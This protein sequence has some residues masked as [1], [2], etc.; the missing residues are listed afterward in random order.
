MLFRNRELDRAF[1]FIQEADFDLFCLQEVPEGFLKRL[2][3]L[4]YHMAS[5]VDAERSIHGETVRMFVVTLSKFPITAQR[6][7]IYPDNRTRL[8]LRTRLFI[9]LMPSR[10]FSSIR[11][12]GGICVDIAVD[13]HIVRVFNLHLMLAYPRVREEEIELA[14][15]EHHK[16]HTTIVCGDFNILGKPHITILNWL[17][18]GTISDVVRYRRER[19]DMEKRFATHGL[20]NVLRGAMTHPLSYSQLDH[21][22]V[23]QWLVVKNQTVLRDRIGSD[24]HPIRVEL[25]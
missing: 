7:I 18:G 14:L 15:V 16:D 25:A 3:T 23:S 19:I 21:I 12:R 9:R 13:G 2:E 24:H 22:L 20:R 1:D 6:E 10:F 5:R 11:N 17:L 8:P 4:P